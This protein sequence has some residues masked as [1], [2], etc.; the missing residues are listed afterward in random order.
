MK[1]NKFIIL[2][3]TLIIGMCATSL[4]FAWFTNATIDLNIESASAGV[5]TQ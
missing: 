3:L 5:I 4:T 2:L 1:I